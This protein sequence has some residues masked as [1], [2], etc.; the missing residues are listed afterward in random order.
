MKRLPR[1]SC[2]S[3]VPALSRSSRQLNPPVTD[4]VAFVAGFMYRIG[5][6]V[7]IVRG[8]RGRGY[9]HRTSPV[10][11]ITRTTSCQQGRMENYIWARGP[12]RIGGVVARITPRK[13]GGLTPKC[14]RSL[15]VSDQ[16]APGKIRV[17]WIF[18][19]RKPKEEIT[20]SIPARSRLSANRSHTDPRRPQG[21]WNNLRFNPDGSGLRFTLGIFQPIGVRWGPDGILYGDHDGYDERGSRPMPSLPTLFGR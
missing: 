1:A 12:L 20:Y 21:E 18:S 14:P 15:A 4:C 19:R 17:Q 7:S 8:K 6:K 2:A 9:H 10:R 5:G 13:A 16:R 3:I 11:A